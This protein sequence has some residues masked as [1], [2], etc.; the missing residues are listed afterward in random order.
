M[1]KD[2]HIKQNE[3]YDQDYELQ[4]IKVCG[5]S[6]KR[7]YALLGR[8]EIEISAEYTQKSKKSPGLVG[9]SPEGE[10]SL[11]K[12]KTFSRIV[13]AAKGF[14]Q[15]EEGDY[16]AVFKNVLVFRLMILLICLLVCGGVIWGIINS[17]IIFKPSSSSVSGESPDVDVDIDENAKGWQGEQGEKP[18]HGQIAIPG[19]NAMNVKVGKTQTS[20]DLYNPVYNNCYFEI[21]IILENGDIIYQSKK[22]P[23]NQGVYDIELTKAFESAG[24]YNALLSYKAFDMKTLAPLNGANLK[25]KIVVQ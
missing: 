16:I 19:K 22:I 4:G 13:Y 7:A 21:S 15:T 11:Y 10:F 23:P 2:I 1:K 17:D 6:K 5:F 18:Q 20:I 9:H 8:K 24:T 14:L 3:Y 12:P 25:T